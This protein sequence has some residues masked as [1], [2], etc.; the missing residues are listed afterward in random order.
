MKF[1][2]LFELSLMMS[3]MVLFLGPSLGILLL[4]P[5]YAF[6]LR[7]IFL[8][9]KEKHKKKEILQQ[10]SELSTL[11]DQGYSPLYAYEMLGRFSFPDFMLHPEEEVF[12]NEVFQKQFQ[13]FE[14]TVLLEEE[15]RSEMSIIALRMGIMKLMP[16]ALLLLLRRFLG[17]E[18]GKAFELITVMFF[19][20]NHLLAD[21]IMEKL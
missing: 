15:I 20:L 18:P 1:M 14:K 10:L 9:E 3:M 5:I 7:R 21:K 6:G 12:R 8:K 2:K 13:L 19:Y 4:L 16:L 17:A 11:L